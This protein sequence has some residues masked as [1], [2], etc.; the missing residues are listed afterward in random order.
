M[1]GAYFLGNQSREYVFVNDFCESWKSTSVKFCDSQ[2]IVGVLQ[3]V[4]IM[5][6]WSG[7]AAWRKVLLATSTGGLLSSSRLVSKF[8]TRRLLLSGIVER[9]K[10]LIKLFTWSKFI[11]L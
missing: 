10:M 1:S 3:V 7:L 11:I 5:C 4:R 6:T 8:M 2:T 9:L